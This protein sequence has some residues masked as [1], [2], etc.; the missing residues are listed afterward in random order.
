MKKTALLL[1]LCG[2][3][4]SHAD[5][6]LPKAIDSKMVLQRDKEVPVWGWADQGEEVTVEFAGQVKKAMPDASGKWMLKLDPMPA[7]AESRTMTVKG[8]NEIKLDDVLVGEVWLASGQSN[9]Q[10]TFFETHPQEW[11]EAQTQKDNRLVRALHVNRVVA[12]F[13]LD[14]ISGKWKDCAEM[15]AQP[16]SVSSAAFFFSLKLQKE[17]GVP[18]A[19]IDCPW[20]GQR[21]ECFIPDEG[22]KAAGLPI[23]R[24]G[25]IPDAKAAEA[26]LKSSANELL[27]AADAAAK[28]RWV[29]FSGPPA[30][31][32]QTQN[33]IWN[34]M[35]SPVA[36]YAVRGA[37]WYQG[38]SNWGQPDYFQK[39]QALS[40]GWSQM[41]QVK[42]IPI[43]QVQIAP[44]HMNGQSK[45]GSSVLG[46]TVWAAQYRGSQE[47]PGMGIV[48]IQDTG[49]E[50]TNIHPRNKK[51]VG[52]RLADLALKTQYGK[53]VV[54]KGPS[55]ASAKRSGSKVVVGF[56]DIDQGLVTYDGKAPSWFELSADGNE[57][58]AAEAA[59][60]GDT[61]EVS[62]QAVPEPKF[63]RMG[64]RD[65][66]LANL[67]D[68]NGWP[69]FAF[70]SQAVAAQ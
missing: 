50:P 27:A 59:I 66:A 61:V 40:A 22:Y 68:K 60:V 11:A 64:W 16:N 30:F 41:F 6:I 33:G 18:V 36:P 42:D 3:I 49:I 26:A 43:L 70:A 52:E 21:I 56:R 14:D 47:I 28:G 51:P 17:L 54:A 38:E 65:V 37:I 69:V 32:G 46:D 10:L 57:F 67:K 9:M 8:K 45:P 1:I 39:L 63:V 15:V 55:F 34:A 35:I 19:F 20:G 31:L 62:A 13:P 4:T 5:A 2:A 25:N 24:R 48:A 29:A 7:S 44:N 58:V 53:N 12:A 23:P